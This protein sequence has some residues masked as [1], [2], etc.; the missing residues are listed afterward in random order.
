[1]LYIQ[2]VP[3]K[4]EPVY[5][6]DIFIATQVL[7]NMLYYHGHLLFFHL[8]PNTWW[9]LNAWLKRN[10][11]NSWMSI[12]ICAEWCWVHMTKFRL[13]NPCQNKESKQKKHDKRNANECLFNTPLCYEMWQSPISPYPLFCA[14]QFWH[15]N[16][17]WFWFVFAMHGQYILYLVSKERGW[18]EFC[19]NVTFLWINHYSFQKKLICLWVSF[20]LGRTVY[21]LECVSMLSF[22][23]KVHIVWKPMIGDEKYFTNCIQF[24]LS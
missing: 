10:H 13:A 17:K 9:Y 23:F 4:K 7:I 1:M 20:F 2:C 12:L 19:N 6:W 14:N 21:Q 5:Q 11:L 22:C 8:I 15:H 16:L 24:D 3:I 18:T